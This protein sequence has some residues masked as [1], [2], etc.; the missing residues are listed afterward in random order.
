MTKVTE[1]HFSAMERLR[2]FLAFIFSDLMATLTYVLME[3]FSPCLYKYLFASS[4]FCNHDLI[5]TYNFLY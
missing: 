4:E 5:M 3:K 2:V 1:D